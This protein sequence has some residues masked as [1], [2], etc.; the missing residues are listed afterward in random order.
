MFHGLKDVD[1]FLPYRIFKQKN[2][3]LLNSRIIVSTDSQQNL[4][5]KC[6]F[7]TEIKL[8]RDGRSHCDC[9]KTGVL[10]KECRVPC[11]L[12]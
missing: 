9:V 2:A 12:A 7:W 1:H 10:L 3:F 5:C 6:Q 11:S 8:K 4:P